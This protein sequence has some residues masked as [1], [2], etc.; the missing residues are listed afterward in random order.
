MVAQSSAASMTW[1]YWALLTVF[2]WGIYGVILHKA[3]GEMKSARI[4][5]EIA[6]LF[7]VA[8]AEKLADNI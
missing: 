6:D 5:A 7:E 4:P 2:S 1:L 8:P 3:R